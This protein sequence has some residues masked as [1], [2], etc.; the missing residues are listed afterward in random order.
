MTVFVIVFCAPNIVF[1][2]DRDG[3]HAASYIVWPFPAYPDRDQRIIDA[4]EAAGV[5]GPADG[6][7]PREVLVGA[8]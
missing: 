6:A 5:I 1:L 7:R 8:P 3:P 4:M 2:A